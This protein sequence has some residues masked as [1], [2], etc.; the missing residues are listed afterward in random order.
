M[1]FEFQ[2]VYLRTPYTEIIPII[3]D[4]LSMVLDANL[5][6]VDDD[7]IAQ[8]II[9][10]VERVGSEFTD[11]N[12]AT[13]EHVVFGFA[14]D[15]PEGTMSA[16]I[17]IDELV[18]HLNTV[19][20][21]HVVKFEDPLLLADITQW[22][23]EIF[24]LEM[25]LRR[26]LT[27]VYLHAYQCEDPY[28]LLREESVQPLTKERVKPEHM[29]DRGENQF[30]HLTF[31]NYIALNRRPDFKLPELL[32]VVRNKERYDDF[33]QELSRLPVA[34]EDDAGFLAGLK[35]RM[36]AIEAMRN[37]CAHNRRPSKR[38]E[39]NY[40]N[41]RPLLDQLLDGYLAR[42][43]WQ[44]PIEEMP[45]ERDARDA[46]TAALE[47]ATWDDEEKAITFF[48]S[49]DDRIRLTVVS[50]GELYDYLS[51][52]ARDAF[53][54]RAPQV[55]GEYLHECDEYGIVESLLDDYEDRLVEFFGADVAPRE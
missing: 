22:T 32:E 25:K 29:N 49:N 6:V 14:V 18:E 47:D 36:D 3:R 30:F 44:E 43:E 42:W 16:R 55:D 26:V 53:Y 48:N 39:E 34:D 21:I 8:M 37:C 33:R 41:A 40:L 2:I 20:I 50:R 46:V 19:P 10:R 9:P 28:D 11:F 17:V 27:L 5:N 31:S 52:L 13:C 24:A 54:A 15:L 35:E 51:A 12:G 1:I 45:W 7:A 38:V 4:G 23:Q